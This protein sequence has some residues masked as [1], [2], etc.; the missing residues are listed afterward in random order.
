MFDQTPPGKTTKVKKINLN[1]CT[2]NARS[3]SS[4]VKLIELKAALQY[5]NHDILGLSEVR[6]LGE[7][8]MEDDGYIMYYIGKTKGLN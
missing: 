4:E 3:L 8:I 7:K 1:I 6:R 5:I 2:L